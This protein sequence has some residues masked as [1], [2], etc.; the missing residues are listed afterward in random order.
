MIASI[1]TWMTAHPLLHRLLTLLL[2]ALGAALGVSQEVS[3]YRKTAETPP[4][5]ACP[6]PAPKASTSKP[7]PLAAIGKIQFGHAGCSATIIGPRRSD[8]RWDVLTAHHCMAGQPESG[9]MELRSGQRLAI[10][11]VVGD[12]TADC[13]WCVT[14]IPIEVLPYALL[15]TTLPNPGDEVWHAGF[16]TD[17]PGNREV[18]R[19]VRS[20]SGGGQSQYRLS[21]SHGDSGGGICL[22]P[23]GYVLSPVCCTSSVGR[24]GDVW[25]ADCIHCGACRPHVTASELGWTP[26]QM[27]VRP[28]AD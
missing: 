1:N 28:A 3:S 2:A 16:G 4:G 19:V 10:T 22:T 24:V 12:D 15:S 8:G 7:D 27:P 6:M 11:Q 20:T 5:N 13:H 23:S 18:G 17:K 14:D 25:G 21:V 26:L 9:W